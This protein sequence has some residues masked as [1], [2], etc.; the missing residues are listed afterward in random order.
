[1]VTEQRFVFDEIADEY[2]RVRPS[3]PR[4]LIDD[5]IAEARLGEG[6]RILEIGCGPGNASL[7]F[8]GR[9][10][11]MLCL[12]PGPHL[13][14]LARRRLDDGA[15]VEVT[16]F[17]EW[18]L[19][20]HA[21]DLVFA[22]QSFHW[23]DPSIALGKCALALAPGGTLA[24]FGNRPLVDGDTPLHKEISEAYAQHA[25]DIV[26]APVAYNSGENFRRL[27][28]ESGLFE[29]AQSHE[30]SWQRDYS[31][32]E[33]VGLLRTQ[34]DHRMLPADRREALLAAIH[35]A[36]ERHGGMRHM[37]YVAALGWARVRD[38]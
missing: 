19:E 1:V 3:Y 21:F 36:V 9:G 16:T 38:E 4:E 25:P 35:A 14:E 22:A 18:P 26:H 8:A 28:D 27:I 11:R 17:E 15:R 6:S 20:R 33:C 12:E 10:F 29:P 24:I 34:S 32:D 5:V 23:I 30:Y 13:A 37:P 7:L 31:A 2:A